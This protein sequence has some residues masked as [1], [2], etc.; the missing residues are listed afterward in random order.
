MCTGA[1]TT[2]LTSPTLN[3]QIKDKPLANKTLH[4]VK[5]GAAGGLHSLFHSPGSEN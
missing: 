4:E 3:N 5:P 1:S 2:V